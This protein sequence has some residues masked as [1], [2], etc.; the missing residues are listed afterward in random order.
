MSDQSNQKIYWFNQKFYKLSDSNLSSV[1]KELDE[2]KETHEELA[3][4]IKTM[5]TELVALEAT[6]SNEQMAQIIAKEEKDVKGLTARAEKLRGNGVIVT[7]ADKERKMKNFSR[8][9]SEWLKR[10][11]LCTDMV[12]MI[13]DGMEKRL[14]EVHKLIG[15]ETDEEAKVTVPPADKTPGAFLKSVAS[16]TKK[17]SKHQK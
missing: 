11:R 3:E 15:I 5:E 1:Q 12:D 2:L 8:Y 17:K 6:P 14:K 13:A 7:P 10:K 4:S 16:P 9:R